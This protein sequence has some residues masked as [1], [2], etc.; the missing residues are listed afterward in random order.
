VSVDAQRIRQVLVNLVDNAANASAE[1][2]AIVLSTRRAEDGR[3]V[4]EVVDRGKGIRAEDLPK[5]FEPFFTT[6][7]D[8][9]GL[10]L[11]IAQKIVRAHGAEL[12]VESTPGE[13][14]RFS[15][16]FPPARAA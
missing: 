8:G 14:A 15:V 3:A 10:G 12:L 6:R 5:I 11:A 7:A 4:V 2:G 9:T 1:G 13:G 16:V